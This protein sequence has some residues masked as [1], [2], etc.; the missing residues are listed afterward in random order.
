MEAADLPI[1]FSRRFV[2][3]DG[4]FEIPFLTDL[5]CHLFF[6]KARL[7]LSEICPET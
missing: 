4:S 2:L 3:V 1:S 5:W 7:R 6:C